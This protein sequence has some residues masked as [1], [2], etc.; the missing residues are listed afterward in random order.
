MTCLPTYVINTLRHIFPSCIIERTWN[1]M[2][3]VSCPNPTRTSRSAPWQL[4]NLRYGNYE[5]F[6]TA[7]TRFSLRQLRDLRYGCYEIFI[8]VAMRSVLWLLRDIRYGCWGLCYGC[9]DIF[10]MA[11]TSLCYGCYEIFATA[12]LALRYGYYDVCTIVAMR[13]L[14]EAVA[15]IRNP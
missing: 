14:K 5:I 9:Y 8:S 3:V 10:A 4:R 7:A 12:V 2:L 1:G 11:A 6:V 15:R 13:E